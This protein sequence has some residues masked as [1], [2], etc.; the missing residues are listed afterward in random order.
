[1]KV[2]KLIFLW[3][4]LLLITSATVQ[5]IEFSDV[6]EFLNNQP[7]L[8]EFYTPFCGHCQ[9]FESTYERIGQTLVHK[10]FSIGKVNANTNQALSSRF[11]I[12]SVP[13]LYYIRSGKTYKYGGAFTYDSIIE[14]VNENYKNS[15]SLP[16]WKNPVGPIGSMKGLFVGIGLKLSKLQPIITQKLGVPEWLAFLIMAIVLSCAILI[17]TGLGIYISISHIKED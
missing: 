2:M 11:S 17:L 9:R 5:E 8:L 6:G 15:R 14:F 4:Q 1:M 7:L 13:S 16:I 3:I 10:G 12:T